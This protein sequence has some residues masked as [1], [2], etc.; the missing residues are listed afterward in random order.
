MRATVERHERMQLGW[1]RAI[2]QSVPGVGADADDAGQ[3]SVGCS[4]AD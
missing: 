1:T 2:E 3:M 4:E